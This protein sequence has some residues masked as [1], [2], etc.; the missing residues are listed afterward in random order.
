[1]SH[2]HSEIFPLDV[3]LSGTVYLCWFFITDNRLVT[4]T[5]AGK[6]H[7]EALGTSPPR[8]LAESIATELLQ[9]EVAHHQTSPHDHPPAPRHKR[10]LDRLLDRFGTAETICVH[11]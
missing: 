1:M 8:A 9:R 6:R 7:T 5:A 2:N 11:G 4:V 10:W 3:E